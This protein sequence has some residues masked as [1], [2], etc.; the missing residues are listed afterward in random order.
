MNA[1]LGSVTASLLYGTLQVKDGYPLCV[2][3]LKHPG[4][5]GQVLLQDRPGAGAAP[6][7][8]AC[9]PPESGFLMAV[10]ARFASKEPGSLALNIQKV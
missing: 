9:V 4:G 5:S 1:L 3:L 7:A 2:A 8:P 6:A 10:R